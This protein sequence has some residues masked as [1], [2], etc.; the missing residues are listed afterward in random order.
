MPPSQIHKEI[1]HDPEGETLWIMDI[2]ECTD[3][4]IVRQYAWSNWLV[5]W[6]LI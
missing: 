4:I 2:T 5:L 6:A 1:S 3:N